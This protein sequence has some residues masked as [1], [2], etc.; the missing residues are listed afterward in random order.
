MVVVVVAASKVTSFSWPSNPPCGCSRYWV[1]VFLHKCRS[2]SAAARGN[3]ALSVSGVPVHLPLRFPLPF[4]VQT[5]EGFVVRRHPWRVSRL[6]AGS[7]RPALTPILP[8]KHTLLAPSQD[9]PVINGTNLSAEPYFP[10]PHSSLPPF[11]ALPS[12]PPALPSSGPADMRQ[13]RQLSPDCTA[14][15]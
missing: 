7:S 2:A 3:G 13:T 1:S 10:C 4:H 14:A 12:L 5:A 11:P 9:R 6:A 8:S 15:F